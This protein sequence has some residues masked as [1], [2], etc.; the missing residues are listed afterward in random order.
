AAQGR[1]GRAR[2][3]GAGV[4][5]D[6]PEEGVAGVARERAKITALDV[7]AYTI[8]TD[9]PESDG[10]LAWS[11][12]TLVR[13]EVA[14]AGAR[15]WGWTYADRAT[16]RLVADKLR[17]EIVGRDAM[18]TNAAFVAMTRAVRNL[19]REGIASM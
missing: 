3:H 13:V 15:G 17:G 12:T 8:P 6:V 11:A 16:A 5:R 10:T 4:P 1:S 19:G 7:A 18:D 14:A 9:K 2:H